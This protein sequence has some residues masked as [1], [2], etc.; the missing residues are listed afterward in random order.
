MEDSTETA[1]LSVDD[2]VYRGKGLARQE[3][4]VVF[5][6]HVLPKE[7]VRA[8]FIRS[9]RSY[10]EAKLLEVIKPSPHRIEPAC[11][12]TG[13]CPGCCYQH[14]QYQEEVRLKQAQFMNFLYRLEGTD[15]EG[16]FL[17]PVSSPL[18]MGYRNKIVL[19]AAVS[20]KK[21]SLG[22]F[23]EDNKTVIDVAQC[24]LAMQQINELLAQLRNAPHFL[25]S[26]KPRSSVVLRHTKNNGA[27][28]CVG[29]ADP[30]KPRL[31]ESTILGDI[32]VSFGSFFQVNPAVADKL[33]VHVMEILER[34]H[35]DTVIDVY[36][37]VGI[38]A[39]AAA[40]TGVKRVTGIDYDAQG[41]E[42]ARDNAAERNAPGIEFAA[43]PAARGLKRALDRVRPGKTAL[44]LDPPRRGLDKG[45]IEL[46][47]TARPANII[48]VSCAAD[49]LARDVIRLAAAGYRAR[50]AGLF[51]MFPRTPYFESVTWLSIK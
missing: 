14:A 3:G 37:G 6:P 36:C 35:P 26:L 22:Y 30:N 9:H 46:I 18:D 28:F 10:S 31:T 32:H 20:G 39:L 49:T 19:H 4:R 7:T 15:A 43:H 47:E 13:T 38:F 29:K 2:V 48:Y 34:I 8:Q 27:V 17:K 41:I 5:V 12:L 45:V 42:A 1:V 40:K 33:I 16:F 23:A 24:P 25:P 21:V 44:I 51:D 50:N 11:P